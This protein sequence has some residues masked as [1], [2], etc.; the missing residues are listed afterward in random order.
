MYNWYKTAIAQ[1]LVYMNSAQSS[2]PLAIMNGD[3]IMSEK[4]LS[5]S[6]PEIPIMDIISRVDAIGWLSPEGKFYSCSDYSHNVFI[7]GKLKVDRKMASSNW[8]V[9]MMAY[10]KG[11]VRVRYDGRCIGFT[12]SRQ[13]ISRLKQ[14]INQ[15]IENTGLT[16]DYHYEG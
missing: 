15:I 10:S 5:D 6:F 13:G 14:I 11:W 16:A 2:Y 7:R 8:A 12:G 4:E 1:E 3:R 9:S